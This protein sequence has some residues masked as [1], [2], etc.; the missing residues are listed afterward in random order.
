MIVLVALYLVGQFF[1]RD[2]AF[3]NTVTNA[4]AIVAAVAFWME[5]KSNEQINE[6]QLFDNYYLSGKP[7]S[8]LASNAG[9]HI[10]E[11]LGN[12]YLATS[13][14]HTGYIPKD[15]VSK[16]KINYNSGGGNSSGGGDWT[17]P[18]L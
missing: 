3:A 15:M 9:V 4:L 18:A 11:D 1:A 12:C 8:K 6:A 7:V 17:P 13:G 2:D 5:F 16:T 10:L 14:E